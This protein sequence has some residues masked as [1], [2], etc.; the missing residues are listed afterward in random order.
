MS[1]PRR[2]GNVEP[3]TRADGTIYY[4]ARI[5]LMQRAAGAGAWTPSDVRVRVDIPDKWCLAKSGKSARDRAAIYAEARQ[6]REDETHELAIARDQQQR[7]KRAGRVAGGPD[8]TADEWHE[9]FLP[10]KECGAGHRRIAG[11]TWNK[12]ISPVIG[13]KPVR[14][15]T[16]DDVEDVRDRIDRAIDAGELRGST[17]ASVWSVLTSALK[18]MCTTRYRELRVHG[19]R[20]APLHAAVEPP[21]KGAARQRPWIYPSEWTALAVFGEAPLRL[22]R[23]CAIALYTGL[24]PN[25]LAAVTCGDVDLVGRVIAVSK[26]LDEE[27]AKTKAPKTL[28][29]RRMVPIRE[30]LLPLLEVLVSG[31]RDDELLIAALEPMDHRLAER[32]RAAL[33][34]ADVTRPRLTADTET[35][36]PVDF[37]S[38][39]DTHAT[40]LALEG[41]PLEIIKRRLGHV[42]ADTTDRYI[43]QAEAF[44]S[45]TLGAPFPPLP[46]E[47]VG[48]RPK[49]IATGPSGPAKARNVAGP[50][51]P[52]GARGAGNPVARVGF[53][54]TTFGL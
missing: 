27:T 10:R 31:R 26:A 5:R 53:E 13:H 29:G 39:R 54:P 40:W 7:A 12:W 30:E 32:F 18:A 6:E 16:R 37:R 49:P 11:L 19:D 34:A 4:R 42:S 23:L 52:S 51:G 1:T 20:E 46:D 14:A 24:R 15:L 17:P 45:E 8:E 50:V 25:E 9:R 35:E 48:P 2:T 36:E 22:R 38:L 3:F 44:T 43:K 21:R 33:A 41:H 28:A 47:L